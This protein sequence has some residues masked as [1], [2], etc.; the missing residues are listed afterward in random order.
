MLLRIVDPDMETDVGEA[1]ALRTPLFEPLLGG[2][3]ITSLLPIFGVKYGSL[4]TGIAFLILTII[5][6][7]LAKITG[8]WNKREKAANR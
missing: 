1:F 4:K 2:G 7:I 5:G 3:L 8:F 6:I